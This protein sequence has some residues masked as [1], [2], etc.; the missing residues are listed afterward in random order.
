MDDRMFRIAMGKFATGVTVITTEVDGEVHGM[1]ANAFMSV[2]LDPKLVLISV[3][4]KAR[5]HDLIKRADKFAVN[6]LSEEQKEMSMIF[7]GQIK[8]E[9]NVAF[10]DFE[11]TPIIKDSIVNL[12][13]NVYDAHEAGDHTLFVG[14][15]LNLNVQDGEPLAFFE[16]KYK[17][18]S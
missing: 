12:A 4:D 7:A 5:M 8:E 11:G 1:T 2:S 16:G 14:E 17:E 15:V 9:R 6:I 3:G 13:C 10:E 18:I